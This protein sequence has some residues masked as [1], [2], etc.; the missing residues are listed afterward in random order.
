MKA[1]AL[2]IAA[3]ILHGQ[4]SERAIA[5]WVIRSGG[6]VRPAGSVSTIRQLEQLP[7]GDL[8]IAGIDFT[9]S[10]IV[11]EDMKRLRHLN[12]IRELYLPA[13]MWNEG[14]GSRRDSNEAFEYLGNLKTLERIQTSVHFL[15]TM[16]I[17]DK[18]IALLSPLSNLREIRM[19]QS[20]IKGKT[21]APFKNLRSIDM[22]YTQFDD[23][24]MESLQDKTL[25]ER[26]IVKDTLVT[27]AGV[28]FLANLTRL[29]Y[30]D[31]YGCR[32]TD[33]GML[34]LRKLTN[35]RVL[36][37]LGAK[38]TDDGLDALAGMHDLTDLNLYRSSVTNAGLEKLKRLKKLTDLDLRYSRATRAGV[39]GLK[40]EIPGLRVNF[41]DSAP[42]RAITGA[43]AR[44]FGD[45]AVA[46]WIHGLGGS[47]DTEGGKVTSVNLGSTVV[48]D[49]QV[50]N[51][52][53]LSGLRS[54]DLS[55]TEVGDIGLRA[56]AAH[57]SLEFVNLSHTL[58]SDRGL[59]QLPAGVRRLV[60]NH[61]SV[62]GTALARFT[63]LEELELSGAP[64]TDQSIP[65]IAKL[66]ELK[67]LGLSHTDF[68]STGLEP[69][70]SLT[71][72][73]VL[74]LT[75]NDIDDN[76]LASIA[77]LTSLV[78]LRLGYGRYTDAGLDHLKPLVNLEMLE[79]NRTRVTDKGLAALLGLTRLRALNL[80]YTQVTDAGLA[81]LKQLPAL[82]DLALDTGAI[83]DKGLDTL[84]TMTNLRRLNLYHTLVT[85]AGQ[86]RLQAALPACRIV[87]DRDSSLPNRRGS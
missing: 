50:G 56:L 76:G 86:K 48:T 2:L 43:P 70:K 58:I 32:V 64:V 20:R 18:G 78:E 53:K 85:E 5:E 13:P 7:P 36:N 71:R 60:L 17:Q 9:G 66:A 81:T 80:N 75:S 12:A 4:E 38:I 40:R 73:R 31:L 16:N 69:L 65:E 10:L 82:Q 26:L 67:R 30:L 77:R 87:F 1:I 41:L 35:L 61:T 29:E 21:L 24:G 8:Q 19:Q 62:R 42:A 55:A 27:D 3:G 47:A 14:A 22:S 28:S 39:E 54:I 49:A 23:T 6:G 79:L 59:E 11:P 74:D 15:T 57:A 52:A 83:T 37:L 25:L 51:L 46:E 34:A 63:R 45:A 44:G 33:A 68:S 72:L 84:A